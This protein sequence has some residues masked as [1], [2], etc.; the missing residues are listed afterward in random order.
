MLANYTNLEYDSPSSA[1][2][3]RNK[4]DEKIIHTAGWGFPDFCLLKWGT[5]PDRTSDNSID[6]CNIDRD[7]CTSNSYI[8]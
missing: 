1:N 4:P 3:W 7:G 8:T 2:S 5:N 6:H